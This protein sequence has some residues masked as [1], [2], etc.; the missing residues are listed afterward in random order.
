MEKLY[1]V[2]RLWSYLDFFSISEAEHK[3]PSFIRRNNMK[4]PVAE[5]FSKPKSPPRPNTQESGSVKPVSARSI[6]EYNL[7]PQR[8]CYPSTYRR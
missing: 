3:P 6:Q 4:I 7:C 8:A 1:S 2:S 5:Y